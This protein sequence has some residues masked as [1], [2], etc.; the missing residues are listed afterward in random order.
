MIAMFI[1]CFASSARADSP[2]GESPKTTILYLLRHGEDSPELVG[3]D[4]SYSVSFNNCLPGGGCC[5]EVLNPLGK[6]RASVLADWFEANKITKTLTH[7]IASHK[8][9]TRQTVQ[10][11]AQKAGLGGDLN[12]DGVPDG[13]DVDQQPG[14]G[15]INVPSMPLEC[16]P[17]W[18]SSSSVIKPQ[19]NYVNTL[20]LGSRAVLCSHSPALYPIMQAF[21]ID[22]SDPEKFPKDSRGRVKGFSNLWIVELQP[23]P[24]NGGVIY[25]GRL[26][27]HVLLDFKLEVSKID[28]DHGNKEGQWAKDHEE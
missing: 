2:Q 21:G 22:T 28:R 3:T 16:D 15:V 19:T 9:R 1:G 6:V 20:P 10:Q 11:I 5:L 17:G 7:V 23:A 13:T 8:L 25:Q 4:P 27:E 26:L 14:D 12:G 24:G 18:T